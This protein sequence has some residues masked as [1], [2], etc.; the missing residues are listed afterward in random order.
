[1]FPFA[2]FDPYPPDARPSSMG[3]KSC[4]CVFFHYIELSDMATLCMYIVRT[5]VFPLLGFKV[6]SLNQKKAL[7]YQNKGRTGSWY[8]F[9]F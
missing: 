1:M 4:Q 3:K 2:I 9:I 5:C 6:Y 7:S 8:I